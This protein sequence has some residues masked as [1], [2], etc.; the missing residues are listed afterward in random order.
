M[1][2]SWAQGSSVW[3]WPPRRRR[4]GIGAAC[5]RGAPRRS[6][7]GRRGMLA[8]GAESEELPSDPVRH[9]A[10]VG[11]DL[12][13][14]FLSALRDETGIDVPRPRAFSTRGQWRAGA[15]PLRHEVDRFPHASRARARL[16][17]SGA[18][19][20]TTRWRRRQRVL[21]EAMTRRAESDGRSRFCAQAPVGERDSRASSRNSRR[22]RL[23]EGGH[24]IAT[25][26]WAA[27][28]DGL[29]RPLPVRP[30]RG[31]LLM[32]EGALSR[33]VIRRR[34][35]HCAQAQSARASSLRAHDHWRDHGRSRV[36]E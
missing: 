18:P 15:P 19:C 2:W 6:L 1:W 20:A 34:W 9:F 29:P 24:L 25:G 8:P 16:A 14:A 13:P 17:T 7:A 31:Q 36:R 35:I 33:H 22:S 11:R 26:A 4:G 23:V 28:L 10:V 30:V 21:L 3:R 32:L 5:G 12:Y 27:Q